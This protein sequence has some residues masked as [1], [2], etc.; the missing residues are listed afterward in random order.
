MPS[1]GTDLGN[2]ASE[3]FFTACETV[4][5][6]LNNTI[7]PA[8]KKATPP[9]S[10]TVHTLFNEIIVNGLSN[11]GHFSKHLPAN[12]GALVLGSLPIWSRNVSELVGTGVVLGGSALGMAIGFQTMR[13]PKVRSKVA[14]SMIFTVSSVVF[15]SELLMF[16]RDSLCL[17]REYWN[18][19]AGFDRRTCGFDS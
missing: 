9:V 13:I 6:A 16:S 11:A 2:K 8:I 18:H 7:G 1:L 10:D 19:G 14:G 12:C 3:M 17:G 5:E 4:G 15:T